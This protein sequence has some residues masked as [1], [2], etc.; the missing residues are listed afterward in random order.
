MIAYAY[1]KSTGK[2]HFKTIFSRLRHKRVFASGGGTPA[3]TPWRRALRRPGVCRGDRAR[4][5]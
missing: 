1:K 3:A 2:D 5:A 4:I